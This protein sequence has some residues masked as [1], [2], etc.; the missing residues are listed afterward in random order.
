VGVVWSVMVLVSDDLIHCAVIVMENWSCSWWFGN[1]TSII[2]LA[3]GAIVR[4]WRGQKPELGGA[5]VI[6]HTKHA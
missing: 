1:E 4:S 2:A 6:M 5:I 3:E